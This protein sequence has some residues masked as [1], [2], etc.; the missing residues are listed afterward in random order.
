MNSGP[1]GA[2]GRIPMREHPGS[3]CPWQNVLPLETHRWEK[4]CDTRS[5]EAPRTAGG[6][7]SLGQRPKSWLLVVLQGS[8]SVPPDL[9][10]IRKVLKCSE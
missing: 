3:L 10:P 2:E 4:A 7:L 5:R 8:C 1:K 9:Y 6:P